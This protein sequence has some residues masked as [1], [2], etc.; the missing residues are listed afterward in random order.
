M[1]INMPA[2]PYHAGGEAHSMI[3]VARPLLLALVLLSGLMPPQT[4]DAQSED[5]LLPVV[6]SW[7]ILGDVVRQV[8]GDRVSLTVLIGPGGDPHHLNA[9]PADLRAIGGARVIF[10]NGLGLEPWMDRHYASAKSRA[11]RV[12]V[13]QGIEPRRV[14]E[15]G[16]RAEPDPHIWFDPTLMMRAA[17]TI[18]DALIEADPA[19]ADTYSANGAA[20]VELLQALDGWIAR[21]VETIPPRQRAL[22]TSHDTFWYF[23]RRYGF[24]VVGFAIASFAPDVEPSARDIAV[25]VSRIR[26]ARVPAIF[27]E[28]VSDSRLL[29]RAATE[30]NVRLAPEL[31]TDALGDP[32]SAGG[33]YLG[34]MQHNAST[35]VTSLGGRAEA[36]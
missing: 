8:G 15:A 13:S 19:N 23:S 18:R 4:S 27:P 21:Q 3:L 17:D 12:A 35:I 20:Y 34:M 5:A 33:T 7:S 26:A 9:S 25:L 10:E 32:S 24:E 28:T 2:D 14:D 29:Q 16:R 31:Y 30:A 11:R 6:V 22:V 36:T 1:N